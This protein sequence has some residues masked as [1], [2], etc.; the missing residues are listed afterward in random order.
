MLFY[1]LKYR[2]RIPGVRGRFPRGGGTP[3]YRM[4]G[5]TGGFWVVFQAQNY[6]FGSFSGPRIIILGPFQAPAVFFW[7]HMPWIAFF[8][9]E[10]VQFGYFFRS[11][12][13]L[14]IIFLGLVARPAA[15]HPRHFSYLVPPPR[16]RVTSLS[17]TS[18]QAPARPQTRPGPS[19]SGSDID[20][21]WRR[22]ETEE[23]FYVREFMFGRYIIRLWY[24]LSPG[25][26]KYCF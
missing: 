21:F 16:A 13:D 1:T 11:L 3:I 26:I 8:P 23:H 22:M 5:M 25:P 4:T 15:G 14:Q 18:E 2:T 10:M 20:A 17:G 12:C 6:F 19:T 7:V 9:L 24:Y